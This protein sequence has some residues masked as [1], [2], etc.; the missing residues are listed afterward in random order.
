MKSVILAALLALIGLVVVVWLRRSLGPSRGDELPPLADRLSTGDAGIR[1]TVPGSWEVET[2]NAVLAAYSD[3]PRHLLWY[4]SISPF[5][6]DVSEEHFGLLGRDIG[7]E[8]RRS[9]SP[10]HQGPARRVGLQSSAWRRSRSM[11]SGQW[12]RVNRR[13]YESQG[14]SVGGDPVDQPAGGRAG[15]AF[16]EAILQRVGPTGTASQGESTRC[17]A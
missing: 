2:S 8:A 12:R 1:W 7:R 17:A 13:T 16:L 14:S 3:E 5:G 9:S 15:I 4:V 10:L 6:L 11:A